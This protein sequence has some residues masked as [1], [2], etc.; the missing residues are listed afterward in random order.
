MRWTSRSSTSPRWRGRAAAVAAE[1]AHWR[2]GRGRRELRC[3]PA[4]S[5][6]WAPSSSARTVR[7]RRAPDPRDRASLEGVALGDSIAVNG[8]CLTV[9]KSDGDWSTDVMAETL[10]RSSLG[11]T[12][13]AA[14]QPRA[15]GH[16]AR[17]PGRPPDAGPRRR[18]RLDR[19]RTPGEHW[20]VV[21]SRSRRASPATSSRRA[22]SPSTASRSPSAR[23][24]VDDD[25]PWFEVS[26]IPTTLAQT[27][28]GAG[29]GTRSTWRST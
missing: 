5:K 15:R 14:G 10:R 16:A 11:D 24:A 1:P 6:R 22:R 4:S 26:L 12:P 23:S 21:R 13:G 8:V 9:E 20:E 2:P 25:Q 19:R 27:T 29:P 18:R 3:S 28:L 17:A 7:R